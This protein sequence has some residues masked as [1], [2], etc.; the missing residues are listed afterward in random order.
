MVLIFRPTIQSR[1]WAAAKF[2]QLRHRPQITIVNSA[3]NLKFVFEGLGLTV[4]NNLNPTDIVGGTI[5]KIHASTNDPAPDALFDIVVNTPAASWYDA[6]V[7]AAAG[8]QAPFDALTSGWA[9]SFIGAAGVDA[10]GA[11]DTND[12]FRASGGSDRLDG[13][14]DS[15]G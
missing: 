10:F 9:L 5:T 13:G 4:D 6:V 15:T 12:F 8:N 11:G 3:E 1:R 7:A 14:L 2:N